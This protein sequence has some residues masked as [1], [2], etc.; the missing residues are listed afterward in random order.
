MH[1]V[2]SR[3]VGFV[4]PGDEKS[5]IAR[6]DRTGRKTDRNYSTK[7]IKQK[8]Q[9]G[10]ETL[11]YRKRK[12]PDNVPYYHAIYIS[13]IYLSIYIDLFFFSENDSTCFIYSYFYRFL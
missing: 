13:F 4:V 7:S 9:T 2:R 3:W 6:H 12:T 10:P 11:L 8:L 5:K 1:I